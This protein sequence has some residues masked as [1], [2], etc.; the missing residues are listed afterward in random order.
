MRYLLIF[1]CLTFLN[2]HIAAQPPNPLL[3]S[4][5][6]NR[7]GEISAKELAQAKQALLGLDQNQ[8]G[9]LTQEE[10]SPPPIGG[11]GRSNFPGG[12]IGPDRTE[13]KLT[14]QF[15]KDSNGY[16]DLNERTNALAA[17]QPRERRSPRRGG[18]RGEP[19]FPGPKIQQSEVQ[20]FPQAKLY[21]PAVLRTIFITFDTP[22]WEDQMAKFKHTDVE[23]PA[24]VW[25]DGKNYPLVGV[26]FRGQSSFGHVSA[27]SKRSLNLSMDFINPDQTLYGYKTLNLLNCNGDASFL[28]SILYSKVAS[29]YLPVPKA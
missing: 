21:D 2:N 22:D 16:L 1:L 28:S 12:G 8:D 17:V 4:L 27:G 20:V 25:V 11:F 15:D 14:E 7:D 9:Q 13:Q 24:T 26:K 29:A 18:N 19:G 3:Q 10:F 23:M 5:D 6:Q